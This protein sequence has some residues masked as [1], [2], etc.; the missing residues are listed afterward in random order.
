MGHTI[1]MPYKPDQLIISDDSMQLFLDTAKN[2][3]EYA[4]QCVKARGSFHFVLA[5][6][7]TPE[8]LYLQL[9]S[10]LLSKQMPWPS[11]HFYFGDER[12]V[13]H[14]HAD[15][16][17]G[18]AKRSLFDLAPVPA[19]NIHAIPTHCHTPQE[20][21]ALYEKEVADTPSQDLVLLGIGQDG[22]TASLFPDTD[23]LEEK[24]KNATA[25]FVP[26]LNSWRISLTYPYINQSRRV[27]ILIQGDNKS[28]IVKQL[29]EST[30]TDK[31]PVT[32]VR[33]VGQLIWQL[34]KDAYKD[35][36]EPG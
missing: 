13:A 2:I 36:R 31:Y 17:Y 35:C 28:T 32:S 3:V 27:I 29:L 25:V 15:S 5:G 12:M 14:D 21:A 23:I 33:P 20:C 6:G 34:D 19:E 9:S 26:K 7:S 24:H 18:M 10:E 4:K 1:K 22:H 11:C 30:E 16:N 8:K